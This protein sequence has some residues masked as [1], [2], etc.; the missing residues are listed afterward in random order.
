MQKDGL[1]IWQASIDNDMWFVSK[2][3]GGV[4]NCCYT[5]QEAIDWAIKY[6]RIERGS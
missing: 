2:R 1:R 4:L 5:W 6:L 3:S